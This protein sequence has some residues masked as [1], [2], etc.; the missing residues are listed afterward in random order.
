MYTAVCS[1][2]VA[3]LS[4]LDKRTD[5]VALFAFGIHAMRRAQRN[6]LKVYKIKLI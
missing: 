2:V 4:L 3:L 6:S 1:V 5:P